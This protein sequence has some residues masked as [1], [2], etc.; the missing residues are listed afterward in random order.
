M[1][2]RRNAIDR[3]DEEEVEGPVRPGGQRRARN[4]ETVARG[5]VAHRITVDHLI[6]EGNRPNKRRV[7]S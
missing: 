6:R 4:L 1:E 7:R 2:A 3:R 5:E